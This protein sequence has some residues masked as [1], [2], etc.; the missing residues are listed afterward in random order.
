M[1]EAI[2]GELDQ[3][4]IYDAVG[5]RI[6][7]VFDAQVVDIG[8]YDFESSGLIHFPYAIERGK[9]FPDEPMGLLVFRKHVM[10]ETGEPLPDLEGP[11]RR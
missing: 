6:R 3:Q 11:R 4:A 1:Q 10:F 5:D 2:A 9:R 7:D 8:I